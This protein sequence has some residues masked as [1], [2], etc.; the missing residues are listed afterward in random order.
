MTKQYRA[1]ISTTIE[2]A[3]QEY[4]GPGL[5]FM[6]DSIEAKGH[7]PEKILVW[8]TLHFLPGSYCCGEPMCHL[9]IFNNPQHRERLDNSEHQVQKALHLT[10]PVEIEFA[11]EVPYA[12]YHEGVTF[13]YNQGME[14]Y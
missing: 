9:W 4:C 11:D 3:V 6:V 5:K 10:Q 1:L 12:N 13:H 8:S 14:E 7:P 2:R